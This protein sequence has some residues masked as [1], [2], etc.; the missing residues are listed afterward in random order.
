MY[1]S[2]R[3][4]TRAVLLAL[5]AALP[6]ALAACGGGTDGKAAADG[7]A[8]VD[9]GKLVFAVNSEPLALDPHTSPQDVTA[10][11]TRP[12]LDSLV[13]LDSAG[14]VKP[15]LATSWKLSPDQRSYTFTLRRDVT[16]SD[17]TPFDAAAVKA[18]L[19]HIVDPKTK[20]QLAASQFGPYKGTDVVDRYTAR[21]N[22]AK[23]HS[24]FLNVLST[25][26]FGMESPAELRKGPQAQA[27]AIVGTGP[28]IMERYTPHQGITYRRNPA[29]KWSSPNAAHQGP[30]RLAQLEIKML[31]EDS[32]RY[33]ALT[34]GQVNAITAVPPANLRL[35]DRDKRLRVERVPAG[36]YSYFP[37]TTNGIFTDAKVRDA[38]RSAVDFRTLVGSLYFGAFKKAYSPL[39]PQAPGYD[40]AT[41]TQW[42]YDPAK[43]ARLL[44]EAGWT[45]R[46][47]QGYR[48]KNGHRLTVR[49]PILRALDRE[50]RATLA[51]QVQA[52]VKK[53]GFEVQLQNVTFN[54]YLVKYGKADYD[55]LDY[56]MRADAD[57]LRS[58]FDTSNITKGPR[59]TQNAAR[60]S[61]KEVD[62]WFQ[63]ALASSDQAKRLALYTQVQH[64]VTEQAVVFP[65]YVQS[66]LLGRSTRVHG[67]G[68]DTQSF[69][70]FQDAW[71]TR[72]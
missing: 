17:G 21:V 61:D 53:L 7:G 9:G 45:A 62:G 72:G 1:R 16:F 56:S 49:W 44:D 5:T 65:V 46:D 38:F 57:S 8:P 47:G 55:L 12:V 4:A 31:L 25:V 32:V 2:D 24:P 51:E 27:S 71:I 66:V 50:S 22:F 58:L 36:T 11:F 54:E 48:T 39:S 26:F 19:D 15:W 52:E 70:L 35:A 30:A 37:N 64:K 59:L 23:P 67:I 18:N 14:T 20:S 69:P 43:A 68:F 13:A 63:Q 42:G 3:P 41:E 60:Y 28:F 34:S 29:Y 33:G 6:L 10:I 40:K